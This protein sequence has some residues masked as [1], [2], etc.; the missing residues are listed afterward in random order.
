MPP[1]FA[2]TA[3]SLGDIL[4]TIEL[5]IK[6]AKTVRNITSDEQR[7]LLFEIQSLN[8]ALDSI[9]GILDCLHSPLSSESYRSD[10]SALQTNL[11]ISIC[12][13]V[14]Q[15]RC[16]LAEFLTSASI[17]H[18]SSDS[19]SIGTVVSRIWWATTEKKEIEHLRTKLS[20]HRSYLTL[21]LIQLAW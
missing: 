18:S 11:E 5:L 1:L 21:Y 7:A 17:S 3:G 8:G 10:L 2:F 4:S 15:C 6:V 16:S 20:S 13:E 12:Q 19:S 14:A 9:R